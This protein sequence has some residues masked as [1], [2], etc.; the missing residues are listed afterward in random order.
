MRIEG[1]NRRLSLH[2]TSLAEGNANFPVVIVFRYADDLMAGFEHRTLPRCKADG[3]PFLMTTNS[4]AGEGES[5]PVT[6]VL[7][8]AAGLKKQA[9]RYSERPTWNSPPGHF[10]VKLRRSRRQV[11]ARR[12]LHRAVDA[13][14]ATANSIPWSSTA[15]FSRNGVLVAPLRVSYALLGSWQDVGSE[16]VGRHLSKVQVSG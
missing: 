3:K 4:E 16:E 10:L 7:N 11:S 14:V 13:Q 12:K 9:R 6:V 2:W 8:W 5:A 15:K 1:S